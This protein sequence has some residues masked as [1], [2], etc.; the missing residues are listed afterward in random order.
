MMIYKY[1]T[2]GEEGRWEAERG[3]WGGGGGGGGG[4]GRDWALLLDL[5]EL[6]FAWANALLLVVE[7]FVLLPFTSTEL[8]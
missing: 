2:H 8:L 7:C 4:G 5:F 6:L 3:E 1:K